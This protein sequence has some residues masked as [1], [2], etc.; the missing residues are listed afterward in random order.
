MR[1][2]DTLSLETLSLMR[3]FELSRRIERVP[4]FSYNRQGERRD[5]HHAITAH[6]EWQ[7][8]SAFQ[9]IFKMTNDDVAQYTASFPEIGKDRDALRIDFVIPD[10][11]KTSIQKMMPI[12]ESMDRFVN[13]LLKE[14][15]CQD[16]LYAEDDYACGKQVHIYHTPE[17]MIAA[18]HG[19]IHSKYRGNEDCL[20][21]VYMAR[22]LL[23]QREY[24]APGIMPH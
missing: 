7:F 9:K 1:S 14:S 22:H 3:S 16:L 21:H 6:I 18:L 4:D 15:V 20:S 10:Q 23:E 5:P 13:R 17:S 19:L 11:N 24:Y 2:R 12:Y 8:C